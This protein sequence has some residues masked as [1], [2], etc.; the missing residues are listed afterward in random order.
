MGRLRPRRDPLEMDNELADSFE[1]EEEEEEA[2]APVP[3]RKQGKKA[4][5]QGTKAKEQGKTARKVT[6]VGKV[7]PTG[8]IGLD[9]RPRQSLDAIQGDTPYKLTKKQ[10]EARL[11]RWGNDNK[12]A[13]MDAACA[14]S[15]GKARQ[16]GYK[17]KLTGT[18]LD[19]HLIGMPIPAL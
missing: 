13:S 12:Q 16:K 6:K 17:G 5:E 14:A 7:K 19:R 3:R 11:K 8:T 1:E 15:F 18:E 10:E 2:T 4:K 9:G